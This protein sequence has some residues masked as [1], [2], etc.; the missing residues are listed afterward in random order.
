V[1]ALR[2][3]HHIGRVG[4][5]GEVAAGAGLTSIHFVNAN[6]GDPLVSPYRGK[7]GRFSTNPVCIAIPGTAKTKPFILDMATSRVALGKVRVAYNEGKQVVEGALVDPSGKPTT[8]PGVIYANVGQVGKAGEV[9]AVLPFGEHKGYGLALVCEILAGAVAGSGTVQPENPRNRGIVNGM[10]SFVLD[11][12]RLTAG[13]F[14]A[15][16]IDAF[17]DYVKSCPPADPGLPVLIPGE[18]ERL[19]REKRL[20]EGIPIDDVTWRQIAEVATGAGVALEA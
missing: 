2:N 14:I 3:T 7:A 1:H 5:Y 9:G 4:A 20:A 6:S 13:D 18:P 15:A 16:E 11:P 19:S 10:L 17:I 8:D 12:A